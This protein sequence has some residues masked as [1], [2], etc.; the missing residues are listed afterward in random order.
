MEE[1]NKKIMK[2][3]IYLYARMLIMMGLSFFTTRI[4]LENLVP[5]IM[6]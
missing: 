4:V 2:N 1:N 5:R 3:T 6:A